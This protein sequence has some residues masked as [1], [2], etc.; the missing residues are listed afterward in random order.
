MYGFGFPWSTLHFLAVT[1]ALVIF[2]LCLLVFGLL[3]WSWRFNSNVN[4][5]YGLSQPYIGEAVDHGLS[6]FRH[7]DNS[8]AYL[9]SVMQSTEHLTQSTMPALSQATNATLASFARL[10]QLAANP[11][12]KLSLA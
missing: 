9:E 3:Y 10:Q 4:Y 12:F 5:Y 1:Q 7:V 6:M 2:I 8:S 11:T